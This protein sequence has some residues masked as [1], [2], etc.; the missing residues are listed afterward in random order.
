MKNKILDM[1]LIFFFAENIYGVIKANNFILDTK[2]D[3]DYVIGYTG[4][5]VYV[6]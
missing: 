1:L 2:V 3:Y 5:R 6:W 4:G